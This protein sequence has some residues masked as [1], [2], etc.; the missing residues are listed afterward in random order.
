MKQNC[1]LVE[2]YNTVGKNINATT[3]NITPSFQIS[4]SLSWNFKKILKLFKPLNNIFKIVWEKKLTYMSLH[5]MTSRGSNKII[6]LLTSVGGLF[7]RFWLTFLRKISWTKIEEN[8]I[9]IFTMKKNRWKYHQLKAH[10]L[11]Q[12][13]KIEVFFFTSY[14]DTIFYNVKILLF[15]KIS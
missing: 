8:V 1:F 13:G 2:I 3:N 6:W 9:I 15:C 11:I 10:L 7:L 4:F 12:K 5:R 14:V